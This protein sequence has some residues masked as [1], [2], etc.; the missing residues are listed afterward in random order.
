[1]AFTA[2]FFYPTLLF[3]DAY[4]A[5]AFSYSH[6]SLSSPDASTRGFFISGSVTHPSS[7]L[8][9]FVVVSFAFSA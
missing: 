5:M 2:L 6:V 7:S 3:F 1:V 4:A 9:P 8:T